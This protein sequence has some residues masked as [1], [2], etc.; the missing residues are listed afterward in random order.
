MKSG[1][2][3]EFITPEAL[4]E[5][6]VKLKRTGYTLFEAYSP[7]PLEGLP[8]GLSKRRPRSAL[9][10]FIFGFGGAGLAYLLMWWIN[11][12]N[13]PYNV[14]GLPHHSAPAF[15]P[16]TFETGILSAACAIFIGT[17]LKL[18][19]PRLDHPLFEVAGFERATIDRFFLAIYSFDPIFDADRTPQDLRETSAFNVAP[20]G[21]LP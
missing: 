6:A 5:A 3:A 1:F 9:Y 18:G 7:F 19:L 2:V 16:I 12:E 21:R 13:Y 17:M 20:F 8:N 10:A 14:G 15:V 4:V 11:V